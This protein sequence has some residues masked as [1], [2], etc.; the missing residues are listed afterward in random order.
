MDRRRLA[1][2]LAR[3]RAR[4]DRG[5]DRR[6]ATRRSTTRCRAASPTN[7]IRDWPEHAAEQMAQY[8]PDAVVFIVGTNDASIVEHRTTRT[9]TACPTGSRLP[10]CRSTR[11]METLVGGEPTPHGV[12]A[13]PAD[14]R[15]QQPRPRRGAH[16]RV[17]RARK[18]T[19]AHPTSSTS[20]RTSCS[21]DPTAATRDR[22]ATRAAKQSTCASATACTSPRRRRY[23]GAVVSS[24]STRAGR[25]RS[26]PTRHSRSTARSRRAAAMYVPGHRRPLLVGEQ[27]VRRRLVVGHDSGNDPAEPR[28]LA[29]TTPGDHAADDG[30]ASAGDHAAHHHRRRR[31]PTSPVTVPHV[32]SPAH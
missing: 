18:R 5:R 31:R 14:T 29:A 12:L 16:R 2:R 11:M 20:T 9:A 4:P 7:G 25:S 24:C 23:L 3:P 15:R 13:R 28:R 6:R 1:R 32:T 22:S 26:R 30:Q 19:S 8:D 17:M 10:R 27:R 21:S